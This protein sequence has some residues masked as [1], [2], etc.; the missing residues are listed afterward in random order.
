MTPTNSY[1]NPS[2]YVKTCL[3]R[4][5]KVTPSAAP[6][7]LNEETAKT[8]QNSHV[9]LNLL[10][11]ANKIDHQIELRLLKQPRAFANRNADN[12][13]GR[14]Y[15]SACQLLVNQTFDDVFLFPFLAKGGGE[16]Y[17]LQ[18]M[19]G[20]AEIDPNRRFLVL[21]GQA[22]KEHAWLDKLPPNA[23]Y[24]DLYKLCQDTSD[25]ESAVALIAFR[26]IQ[27]TASTANIHVKSSEFGNSMILDYGDKLAKTNTIIFYRFSDGKTTSNEM[28]FQSG[29]VF[30]V[31][32]ERAME[33]GLIIS[34]N[35][36]IREKDLRLLPNLTDKY[37][38]LYAHCEAVRNFPRAR[39]KTN[40][41]LWAGRFDS[42]K[43]PELLPLIA[44][45]LK[46]RSLG[47]KIEMFGSAVLSSFD[48][49]VFKDHKNLKYCG[50]FD[51]FYSLNLQEYD[52]LIYTSYF[53]GL[54]NIILEALSVGMPVIAPNIDGIPEA[55]IDG[56]TGL[57]VAADT[58][59][60]MQANYYADV[61]ETLYSDD[62]DMTVLS[63]NAIQ[64]MAER[65]S[66]ERSLKEISS[67]FFAE[68]HSS[69]PEKMVQ[70]NG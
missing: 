42:E 7:D 53:D 68:E 54:P 56:E 63:Q 9:L 69:L 1:Y 67:L 3:S 40:K 48:F 11:A 4:A 30:E 51:G 5:T 32:S 17:I 37:R 43:R 19:N 64:L 39:S 27:A 52:A 6:S 23:V 66:H 50:E 31:L 12:S 55:V 29:F 41:L 25:V 26:L 61:I 13:V 46:Q 62:V 38:V 22:V 20:I 44:T 18:V 21:F 33:I 59:N 70:K 57:L 45:E 14:A 2:N 16:K 15:L 60:Q 58:S 10:N 24:I 35:K 36:A 28:V 47:L 49:D 65:H 34:D 8:V